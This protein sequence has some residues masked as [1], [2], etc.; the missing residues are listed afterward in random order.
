MRPL[1]LILI[2][3]L[4]ISTSCRMPST[5]VERC[6]LSIEYYKC[7]CHKYEVT[8]EHIGR[9]GDSYDKP[10]EY[11]DKLVGFRPSDWAVL[12]GWMNEVQRKFQRD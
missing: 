11:C 6:V 10:Y 4:I 8:Q 9:V 7:R 12:R 3:V 2:L 1:N 5:E